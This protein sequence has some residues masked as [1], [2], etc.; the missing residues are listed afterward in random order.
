MP[1]SDYTRVQKKIS[2]GV[3]A[4]IC[5]QPTLDVRHPFPPLQRLAG[6]QYKADKHIHCVEAGWNG[7]GSCTAEESKVFKQLSAINAEKGH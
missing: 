7:S 6:Q 2:K 1:A 4:F 5:K 3:R